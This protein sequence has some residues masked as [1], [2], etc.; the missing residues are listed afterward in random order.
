MRVTVWITQPQA[1]DS[2]RRMVMEHKNYYG[3]AQGIGQ[4]SGLYID[5][6]EH[7]YFGSGNEKEYEKTAE[8]YLAEKLKNPPSKWMWLRSSGTFME[9]F[10]NVDGEWFVTFDGHR[11][12]IIEF[13]GWLI[14]EEIKEHNPTIYRTTCPTWGWYQTQDDYSP[15]G[16]DHK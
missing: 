4:Q 10:K 13:L 1:I 8:E 11:H 3:M 12:S 7:P 14:D 9:V 2:L 5:G 16:G 15:K 6:L